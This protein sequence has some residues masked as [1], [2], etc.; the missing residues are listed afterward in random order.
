VILGAGSVRFMLPVVSSL[1]TFF[2]ERPLEIVLFDA[3]E[4]RLDLVDRFARLA[5]ATTKSKHSLRSTYDPVE[6]LEGAE[7]VI[8]QIG[9]NCARKMLGIRRDQPD[10]TDRA[11]DRLMADVP[12]GAHVLNLIE[13]RL[14]IDGYYE[15]DWPPHLSEGEKRAVP[16]QILRYLNGEEYVYDVIKE[17][18]ASPL[19]A[20]LEDPTFAA[21]TNS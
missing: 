6:A 20:W 5:F 9:E 14:P 19:K 16:H 3:D 2:G 1:S 7:L 13:E 12:E 10:P 18:A 8:V 17:H 4:E 15:M 21:R 11:L